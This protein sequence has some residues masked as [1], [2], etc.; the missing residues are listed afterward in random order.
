MSSSLTPTSN[1]SLTGLTPYLP[2]LLLLTPL[3][4]TT[5]SLTHA[6]MEHLTVSSFLRAPSTTTPLART[7]SRTP[8][9][10]PPSP[11]YIAALARATETLAPAWFVNFFSRGVYSVVGLNAVTLVAGGANVW[12]GRGLEGVAWRCYVVGLGAAGAHY[13]FVPG[14]A[15]SVERLF[16]MCVGGWMGE[17]K[18]EEE[19]EGEGKEQ[20]REGREGEAKKAVREWVGWHVVRW[21][22]VDVLAWGAFLVGGVVALTEG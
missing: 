11:A 6:Y 13:A 12:L 16:R 14:V 1:L 10:T 9:T 7:M 17:G 21:A 20:G 22:T 2:T 8:S 5:A 19:R 4:S 3:L 18:E 15:P